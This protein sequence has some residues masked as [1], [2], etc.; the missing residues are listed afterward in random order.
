V[1]IA[2]VIVAAIA[3]YMSFQA[4]V[5]SASANAVSLS[6]FTHTIKSEFA[7]KFPN[8]SKSCLAYVQ[9]IDAPQADAV[10]LGRPHRVSSESQL[11]R[12]Q[13]CLPHATADVVVGDE[14]SRGVASDLKNKAK[15]ALRVLEHAA[16]QIDNADSCSLARE[17]KAVM[18]WPEVEDAV[19]RF[20]S[21][22]VG[23]TPN[24]FAAIVEFRQRYCTE[25]GLA[26]VCD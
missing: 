10:V 1:S 16:S 5:L 8:G 12:L 2:A 24:T 4:N 14:V 6:A 9:S 13:A 7:D 3:A 18:D 11:E 23:A 21:Q 15:K 22:G 25:R 26:D 19:E 20:R 17:L